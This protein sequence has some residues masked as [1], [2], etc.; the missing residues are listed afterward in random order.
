MEF[1]WLIQPL[2]QTLSMIT[3]LQFNGLQ[4]AC[5]IPLTNGPSFQ[6]FKYLW[7]LKWKIPN[8]SPVIVIRCCLF[9]KN[10]INL[11]QMKYLVSLLWIVLYSILHLTLFQ[12]HLIVLYKLMVYF[13]IIGS[14]Q[15][16]LLYL[17]KRQKRQHRQLSCNISYLYHWQSIWKNY[18]SST[19]YHLLD[20]SILSKHQNSDSMR[21]I[22]QLQPY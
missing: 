9:L 16:L 12:L 7:P 10:W 19:L 2:C 1:L 14:L 13:L 18:L 17:S 3:S 15:G 4:L 8:S 6:E 22:Q 11:V 5:E 20:H 21:S